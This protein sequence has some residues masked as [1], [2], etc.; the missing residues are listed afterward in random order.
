MIVMIYKREFIQT[1]FEQMGTYVCCCNMR[2]KTFSSLIISGSWC[3]SLSASL[4]MAPWS[5]NFDNL[6]HS[7]NHHDHSWKVRF[8]FKF[9]VRMGKSTISSESHVLI[10]FS[11]YQ[12]KAAKLTQEYTASA[13]EV[14]LF[15]P[16]STPT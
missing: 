8:C 1:R 12:K 5:V 3:I 7:F 15:P 13:N 10:F 9:K 2:L 14:R 4:I 16:V 11:R 6:L